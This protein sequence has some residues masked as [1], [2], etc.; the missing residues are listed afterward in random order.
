MNDKIILSLELVLQLS[1]HNQI[2]YI[3]RKKCTLRNTERKDTE[4]KSAK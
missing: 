1:K 2:I 3:I 4:R